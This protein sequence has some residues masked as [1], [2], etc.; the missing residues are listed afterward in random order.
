MHQ[1]HNRWIHFRQIFLCVAETH[2]IFLLFHML[3][4]CSFTNNAWSHGINERNQNNSGAKALRILIYLWRSKMQ[5]LVT[6][7]YIQKWI[8]PGLFW[9]RWTAESAKSWPCFGQKIPKIH[10]LLRTTSSILLPW[11]GR[12]TL[13]T[14]EQIHVIVLFCI[15]WSTNKFHLVSQINLAGRYPVHN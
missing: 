6:W 5:L 10:T 8:S 4:W 12:R 3:L 1:K 14:A 15:T 11:L 7:S 13:V 9:Y 2:A